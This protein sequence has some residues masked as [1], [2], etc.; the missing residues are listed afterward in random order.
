[1]QYKQ[2]IT[3]DKIAKIV[4]KSTGY[5][6]LALL[7][8]IFF[9]LLYNA[10]A[11][12]LEVSPLDFITGSQWNPTA[13]EPAYG[14]LP[15]IVSTSIV[16][17][18]AMLIAIPLGVGTAAFISEYASPKLKA[19][20]KPT[21]EMLAAIPSVVIGFLGIVLVGPGIADL[22][23]LPSPSLKM[24]YTL[25]RKPTVKQVMALEHPVGRHYAKLRFQQQH[26]E[27]LPQSCSDS[28]EQS[29]KQ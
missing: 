21:I 25:Y 8:G 7:G 16:S 14:I 24:P 17:L 28:V 26:Q 9:M 22:N 10:I 13:T 6:V 12:F 27:L 5:L 2:R 1:M 11:F 20:L 18:G 15:L 4:F 23:N 19:I 29:V 3:I